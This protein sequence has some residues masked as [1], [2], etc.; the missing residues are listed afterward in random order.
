VAAFRVPDISV[1]AGLTPEACGGG[2][3]RRPGEREIPQNARGR[4]AGRR[5]WFTAQAYD[6]MTSAKAQAA[7][8]LNREGCQAR[9]R[10]G[11]SPSV[12]GCCWRAA[13]VETGVALRHRER[14][15][16]DHSHRIVPGF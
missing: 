7:L 16:R 12:S 9:E 15:Q 10:Y 5:R 6:M 4:R 3:I 8:D 14:R 1:A 2:G 11:R 13:L